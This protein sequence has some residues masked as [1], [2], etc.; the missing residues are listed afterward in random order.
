MK[1][2]IEDHAQEIGLQFKLETFLA[3]ARAASGGAR[4]FKPRGTFDGS[5]LISVRTDFGVSPLLKVMAIAGPNGTRQAI[6]D[7]EFYEVITPAVV[8]ELVELINF[9]SDE[10]KRLTWMPLTIPRAANAEQERYRMKL[11]LQLEQTE[12]NLNI[13]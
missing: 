12:F 11:L 4:Y 5:Q 6:Q 1:Q 7:A 10:I 9:Q 13:E 2:T 3:L 8:C